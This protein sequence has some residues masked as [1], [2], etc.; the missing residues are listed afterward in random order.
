M[1]SATS[2]PARREPQ[3]PDPDHQ[4]DGETRRTFQR[5]AEARHEGPV[6]DL[7]TRETARPARQRPVHLSLAGEALD[8]G[9]AAHVIL[10]LGGER[11][12]AGGFVTERFADP[13]A[14]P[15]Q[16]GQRER[17]GQDRHEREARV[18]DQGHH[19][20]ADRHHRG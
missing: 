18:D 11:R 14:L 3:S 8:L 2:T 16:V 17:Q 7:P 6:R 13:P 19:Q 15:E 4:R 10:D 20:N 1:R 9:D 12:E 5:G